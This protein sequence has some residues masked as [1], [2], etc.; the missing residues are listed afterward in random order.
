[1]SFPLKVSRNVWLADDRLILE[2]PLQFDKLCNIAEAAVFSLLPIAYCEASD[3]ELPADLPIEEGIQER[4]DKICELWNKWF[5]CNRKVKILAST[6]KP[7]ASDGQARYG[8][9][10]FSG[11]VDSTA[12][13]KRQRDKIKY[14]ALYKGADVAVTQPGRFE[15]IKRYA[16]KFAKAH[17]KEL[18][19]LSTNIH[20]LG[21]ASWEYMAHACA[22]VGPLLALSD[23]IDRIYIAATHSG[24]WAREVRLGSHPDLDPLVSTQRVETI[25]DG[26]ELTRPE[27]IALLAA[28]ATLLK[29]LRVCGD[30]TFFG[31]IAADAVNRYNCGNCEKCSYTAIA[32]TLLGVT[33][34]QAPFPAESLSLRRIINSLQRN[35]YK[36]KIDTQEGLKIEWAQCLELLE[37]TRNNI[38]GKE[39]LRVILRKALGKF[40]ED[41]KN[42][43]PYGTSIQFVS[44][45]RKFEKAA[46]LSLDSLRHLKKIIRLF[47]G[48]PYKAFL[49]K[50]V[51]LTK[52]S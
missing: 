27:K 16:E 41:Y 14:L 32:L 46:G 21:V 18:I 13:F 40:Y 7:Q 3:I 25:H 11:G 10:L 43:F 38:E 8:A 50:Y 12:T 5:W 15:E 23:Y 47:R 24:E 17:H 31:R 4:I 42:G 22:M 37:S 20:Y 35:D 48:R 2:Y 52:I 34:D 39:E 51:P 45:W 44:K 28:E 1:M 36:E 9:Q 29:E 26:F 6:V 30:V 19:I 33:S 49:E